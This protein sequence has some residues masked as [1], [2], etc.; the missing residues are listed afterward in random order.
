MNHLTEEQ[1]KFIKK[2]ATD[3]GVEG[4]K[5]YITEDPSP[6]CL[7]EVEKNRYEIYIN[8]HHDP[9]DIAHEIGHLHLGKF[10]HPIFCL[11][12]INPHHLGT[13]ALKNDMTLFNSLNMIVDIFVNQFLSR[14]YDW[15]PIVNCVYALSLIYSQLKGEHLSFGYDKDDYKLFLDVLFTQVTGRVHHTSPEVIE[16]L[17]LASEPS[18]ENL[19]K[20][21]RIFSLDIELL[22]ATN[23]RICR[24][25][26]DTR[27]HGQGIDKKIELE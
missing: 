4:L 5:V 11:V 6:Y 10:Y 7:C 21:C 25:S 26:R 2:I 27:E 23:V 24:I 14:R 8:R 20:V 12:R 22:D 18:L 9:S 3:L 17:K 15:F 1:I 16:I 13:W 19:I